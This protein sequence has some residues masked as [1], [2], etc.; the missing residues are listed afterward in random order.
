MKAFMAKH[1]AT[2]WCHVCGARGEATVDIWFPPNAEHDAPVE[3]PTRGA[4]YLRICKAC[5]SRMQAVIEMPDGN[6]VVE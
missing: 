6:E 3:L 4:R 2:D 1:S 5:A